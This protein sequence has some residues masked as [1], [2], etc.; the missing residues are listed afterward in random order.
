M[1]KGANQVVL[2]S[3]IKKERSACPTGTTSSN[4]E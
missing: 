4:P 3:K 2:A 1:K